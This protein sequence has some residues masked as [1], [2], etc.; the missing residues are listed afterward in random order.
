M[1]IFLIPF[2]DGKTKLTNSGLIR[3]NIPTMLQLSVT[4]V[5]KN[6]WRVF[7][8]MGHQPTIQTPS[9]HH[10]DNLKTLIWGRRLLLVHFL[11]FHFWGCL[12]FWGH[13]H[14]RVMQQLF[15]GWLS[16]VTVVHGWLSKLTVVLGDF[17]PSRQPHVLLS[18][19]ISYSFEINW[20]NRVKD[21]LNFLNRLLMKNFFY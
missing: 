6:W 16:K 17:C 15:N 8:Y 5:K 1:C 13:L 3:S 21:K 7:S 4:Q 2:S 19:D 9:L 12:Y 10:L 20:C 11:E 14:F 18:K